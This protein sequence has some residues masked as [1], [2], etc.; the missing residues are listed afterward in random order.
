MINFPPL[1]GS[2]GSAQAEEWLIPQSTKLKYTQLFNT[3]DL[4]RTGFISGPQA[5]NIFLQSGLP[6]KVLAQIWALADYDVD[7]RLTCE[8]FILANYLIERVQRGE[9]IPTVLPPELVPPAQRKSSV[10]SAYSPPN[11]LNEWAIPQATKL[12]YTQIFNTQDLTRTGFISGPQARNILLQS[13]LPQKVLAQ[14]WALADQDVD[15]RLTCEEFILANYLIERVQRGEQIPTVLPPELVP[16]TQRKASVGSAYSPSNG[17]NEWAIPQSTKLKYTQ[18]FNS[19]DQT[20]TGFISGPQARN[21]LLQSGLPQTVLAQIWALADYDVDGRLTCEEF[22]LATYLIDIV[23]AGSP[24][25]TALPPELIP[26]SQRRRSSSVTSQSSVTSRGLATSASLIGSLDEINVGA[27]SKNNITTFEDKRRENFEKGQAELIKRRQMLL[28]QQKRQEEE[29][30]KKE[31]EEHEKR[32]RIR[33]EKEKRKQQELEKQLQRQRELEAAKEEERLKQLEQ[34]EA[35]RREMERLRMIELENQRK[36]EMLNQEQET[37]AQLKSKKKSLMID[38]E[39]VCN[40]FNQLQEQVNESRKKVNDCKTEIDKMRAERDVKLKEINFL[41]TQ[42]KTLQDR[43]LL[44][45]QDKISFSA[46]LKDLATNNITGITDSAQFALQNKKIKISQLKTQIEECEKEKLSKSK[47]MQNKSAELRQL[48][49]KF[50]TLIS[51]VKAL[52]ETYDRQIQTANEIV[53]S[54]QKQIDKPVESAWSEQ[55][56]DAWNTAH[57]AWPTTDTNSNFDAFSADFQASFPASTTQNSDPGTK[58]RAVFAFEARSQDELTIKDGDIIIVRPDPNAAPGWLQGELDGKIGW[59]PEAYVEPLESTETPILQAQDAF[60][61]PEVASDTLFRQQVSTFEESKPI[62]SGF[63]DNL[64]TAVA[65]TTTTTTETPAETY[66]DISMRSFPLNAVALYEWSTSEPNHLT[67][68]KGDIINVKQLK[69]EWLLGEIVD[70]RGWFPKYIV[71]P[72]SGNIASETDLEPIYHVS[73]YPFQSLEIGDL[74]FEAGELIKVIKKEGDWWSGEITPDRIGIF[75]SNYVREAMVEELPIPSTFAPPLAVPVTKT[76]SLEKGKLKKPE[77]VRVIAPYKATGPEQLN[78][79]KDQLIQVR[80]KNASGWWEGEIQIKGQKRQ[81]GW[82]P[83][84]YVKSLSGSGAG[85]GGSSARSTPDPNKAESETIEKVMSLYPFVAQHDDELSFQANEVIKVLSKDDPTWWKGQLESNNAIGVFPSNYVQSLADANFSRYSPISNGDQLNGSS[86]ERQNEDERQKP[87][88]ELIATEEVYVHDLKNV[89]SVFEKPLRRSNVIS[90]ESL[91]TIFLNWTSLLEFNSKFLQALLERRAYYLQNSDGTVEL[92]GDIIVEYIPGMIDIYI[93][94]CSH[95]LKA[96]KLLQKKTENDEAFRELA[97][98]CSM[99]RKTNG[100]PL[101]AY[102]LKPMQRITKYPLVVKKIL[103]NTPNDHPDRESCERAY[104]L[105]QNLCDAVNEACRSQENEERLD[106][107]QNH[108]KCEGIDQNIHFNSMTKFMGPRLILNSGCLTK[109]NSG[110]E[111]VAFLFNDFFLLTVPVNQSARFNN[112]W[113]SEKGMAN[114]YRMYKRPIFLNDME[115]VDDA[116]LQ[117]V[118]NGILNSSPSFTSPFSSEN[119]NFILKIKSTERVYTFK[120]TS[121][122]DRNNWIRSINLAKHEYSEKLGQRRS[123]LS[124]SLNEPPGNGIGRLLVT[125]LEAV[126]LFT[127]NSTLNSY[128]R[129]SV[130]DKSSDQSKYRQISETKVARSCFPTERD[131]TNNHGLVLFTANWNYSMQ[132]ILK[133]P[134]QN[135]FLTLACFD[136]DPFAPDLL[137]GQSTLS[138]DDLA[139]E[140]KDTTARPLTKACKLKCADK[141]GMNIN[142]VVYLKL[143]LLL[144]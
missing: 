142:P 45:E 4:T 59:F 7:G 104:E 118:P 19:H 44:I 120:A 57:D 77:I 26:P 98:K 99:N 27:D 65:T 129:V 95:Q 76:I 78:L 69:D 122:N 137:I 132:F 119:L 28:E 55:G 53:K 96:A 8:E 86:N 109:V 90:S 46:Q 70:R 94:F 110:K 91:D 22:V 31:R 34:R 71:K 84:S 29:R 40:Q 135:T 3:H 89:I 41:K 108:V 35:A 141:I 143:D 39:Q 6:Q 138:L 49:E 18:L 38:Y 23:K 125:V 16:P 136:E 37:A 114:S 5:R 1:T 116:T 140:I 25:P 127:R 20:R 43:Q 14:I 52:Q 131:K 9:Q 111:L 128:C 144:F 10:G 81:I 36:Q 130:G 12:K 115:L 58:Y 107:I 88:Q 103:S 113:A 67:I 56:N 101:G 105:A 48:K 60:P 21:I 75:P 80:K 24:L 63:L 87:I 82:F 100:L 102:L 133:E 83:A 30:E 47:D 112:L 139:E 15:G 97:K 61:E 72:I 121:N 17:L 79:E 51:R 42:M 13:G 124:L 93:G 54:K 11:G 85:S 62:D 50:E 74:A 73:M 134:L 106:W 117:S 126:Q 123:R 32:E 64:T 66:I 2:D 68:N 92:I 33:L